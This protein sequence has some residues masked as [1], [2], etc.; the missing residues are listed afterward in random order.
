M[1]QDAPNFAPRPPDD[2]A[3]GVSW[4]PFACPPVGGGPL[5]PWARPIRCAAWM[6]LAA[7]LIV[8]AVQFQISTVRMYRAAAEWDRQHPDWSFAQGKKTGLARPSGD[9]GAIGR[10][11]RAA[12]QFWQGA[13]IYETV[14]ADYLAKS[15]ATVS[16]LTDPTLYGVVWL[17]P[18]TPFT[19]I[20]LSPLAYLPA[21]WMALLYNVL[22]LLAVAAAVLMSAR[23]AAHD[24]RRVAD[25]VVLLGALWMLTF[26]VGD[27]QHGNT[28][29]FSMVAVAGHLWLYRRGRDLAAGGALAVAICLKMTPALFLLY[30]LY[31]RSWKVLASSLA[32]LVLLGVV[33]PAAAVGPQRYATLAGTWF[34]N[35]IRPGLVKGSWYP[36]HMNQSLSGVVSRYFLS[37]RDG[38]IDWGPDD[39]PLYQNPRHAWIT[40]VPL[41]DSAAR[42]LLRGGQLLIVAAMAWAIGWRRLPRD[43]GRRGL[44]YALVLLGMMLLNQRTWTH[45]AAVLLPAG[46]AIWQAIAYGRVS[47]PARAWALGLVLAAGAINWLARGETFA[48]IARLAGRTHEQAARW[49]EVGRAAGP[50]CYFFLLMLAATVVLAVSLRRAE[51][52][53]AAQRQRLF[54]IAPFAA[55]AEPRALP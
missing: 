33:V 55:P 22:K 1:N 46:V 19:V 11:R 42:G 43:D 12:R 4:L 37:G 54:D 23:L 36:D 31:Q 28:N 27:V 5:R 52:P 38:D 40:L 53:Y 10:W 14:P 16:A 50:T 51:D 13:N 6:L 26:V 21:N 35:L 20:L 30:W 7:A 47:R 29:I 17:H 41:S 39:D 44:H 9:K 15:T 18:N 8:P 48:L 24:G 25:W 32:A 3:G 45:H 34:Q 49:V 2:A